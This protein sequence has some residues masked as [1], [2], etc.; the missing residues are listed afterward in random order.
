[1]GMFEDRHFDEPFL[2]QEDHS[3]MKTMLLDPNKDLPLGIS[4]SVLQ[5]ATNLYETCI[6]K[7]RE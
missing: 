5:K 4:E 1:M 2:T 6:V 3:R 7:I